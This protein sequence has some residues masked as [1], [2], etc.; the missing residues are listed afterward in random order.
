MFLVALACLKVEGVLVSILLRAEIR[1]TPG[2]DCCTLACYSPWRGCLELIFQ[3]TRGL[4]SGESDPL[5]STIAGVHPVMV[6][7]L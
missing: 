1:S 7:S 4:L 2:L 6:A 3:A 5:P